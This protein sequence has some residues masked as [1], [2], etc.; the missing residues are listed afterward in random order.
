MVCPL[1]NYLPCP[2]SLSE[3]ISCPS[4]SLY[5]QCS[6]GILTWVTLTSEGIT[7]KANWS[8]S[9]NVMPCQCYATA[10]IIFLKWKSDYVTDLLKTF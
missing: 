8:P 5:P 1:L 4:T 7:I 2:K 3:T 6:T 9:S 10:R